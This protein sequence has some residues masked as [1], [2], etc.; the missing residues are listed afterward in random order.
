MHCTCSNEDI[1]NTDV[2][3]IRF[4]FEE[5]YVLYIH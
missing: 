1:K 5:K 3:Y 2:R 4:G